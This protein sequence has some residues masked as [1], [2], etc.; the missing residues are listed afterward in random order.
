MR[1]Q[2]GVPLPDAGPPPPAATDVPGVDDLE[3]PA[4]APDTRS[5]HLPQGAHLQS[6]VGLVWRSVALWMLLVALLTLANVLG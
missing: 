3:A 4:A 1:V 5:V 2:L 6:M